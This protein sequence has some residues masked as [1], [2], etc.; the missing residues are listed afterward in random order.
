M[1]RVVCPVGHSFSVMAIR[2]GLVQ[3]QFGGLDEIVGSRDVCGGKRGET[4]CQ[5]KRGSDIVASGKERVC[6]YLCPQLFA[7]REALGAQL[8][9]RDVVLGLGRF[10]F[11]AHPINR[12]AATRVLVGKFLHRFHLAFGQRQP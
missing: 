8:F 1:V 6:A 2:V 7:E 4:E 12:N 5:R 3:R 10:R 11:G 9:I